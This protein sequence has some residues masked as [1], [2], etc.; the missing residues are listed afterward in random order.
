MLLQQMAQHHIAII[1]NIRLYTAASS[2]ASAT[3][4]ALR[5]HQ[6]QQQQLLELQSLPRIDQWFTYTALN[7]C[8]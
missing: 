6:Q 3:A 8:Y 4:T 2:R 7:K 1:S 5:G